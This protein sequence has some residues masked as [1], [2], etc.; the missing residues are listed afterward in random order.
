MDSKHVNFEDDLK[1]KHE[2]HQAK[3]WKFDVVGMMSLE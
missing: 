2:I 3:L 1:V